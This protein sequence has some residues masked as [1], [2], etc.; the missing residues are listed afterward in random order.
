[1]GVPGKS[2]RVNPFMEKGQNLDY[3]G[4]TMQIHVPISAKAVAEARNLTLSKL[5]FS[6]KNRD[7]LMVFPQHEAIMGAYIAT[8]EPQGRT[9]KFKDKAEA[10]EA[11]RKGEIKLTTPVII[12]GMK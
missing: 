8:A 5:L 2:L 4:D 12:G 3:D 11:Y 7:D 1:M 10:M 6:D 9:R